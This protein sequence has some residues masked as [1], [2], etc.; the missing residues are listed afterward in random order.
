MTTMEQARGSMREIR[1]FVDCYHHIQDSRLKLGG[2]RYEKI[3]EDSPE[4]PED[5]IKEV[6]GVRYRLIGSGRIGTLVRELRMPWEEADDIHEHLTSPLK[7]AEG[8]ARKRLQEWVEKQ[9]LWEEWL[10]KI[11]GVGPVIGAGLLALVDFHRAGNVSQLWAYFGMDVRKYSVLR[12]G[13]KSAYKPWFATEAERLEWVNKKLEKQKIFYE[14]MRAEGKKVTFDLP[15]EKEGLM[16]HSSA[17]EGHEVQT[18]AP[19]RIRG[20]RSDWNPMGRRLCFLLGSSFIKQPA[21]KS[22]YRRQYD[23]IKAEEL[24]SMGLTAEPTAQTPPA[25]QEVEIDEIS[26]EAAAFEEMEE[27]DKK[28][29][30]RGHAD[31]RARRRVIKI[32]LSHVWLK[33]RLSLGLEARPPYVLEHG[34]QTYID[35]PTSEKD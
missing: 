31:M 15:K 20:L 4:K 1:M 26:A 24:A 2:I 35:P 33:G 27:Q 8:Y 16:E 19:R 29:G 7:T 9:K 13:G 17:G 5:L 22:F 25:N 12:R 3:T 28:P 23:I 18:L 11:R 10:G 14:A 32:F 34:H 30:S 6:A 21:A